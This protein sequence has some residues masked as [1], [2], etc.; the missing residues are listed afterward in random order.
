VLAAG[1]EAALERLLATA[2]ATEPFEGPPPRH[3]ADEIRL[4]TAW[5]DAVAGKAEVLLLRGQLASPWLGGASLQVRYDPKRDR[6]RWAAPG[7]ARGRPEARP[8]R[9]GGR[10]GARSPV[11]SRLVTWPRGDGPISGQPAWTRLAAGAAGA[12]GASQPADRPAATVRSGRV[13]S[14]HANE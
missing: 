13:G 2:A 3:L 1:D 5:L 8:R 10:R 6:H 4:V 14:G 7:E 11:P 12:A 9:P